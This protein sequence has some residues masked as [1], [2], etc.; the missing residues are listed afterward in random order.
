MTEPQQA[1]CQVC[2]QVVAV[3][4]RGCV[5]CAEASDRHREQIRRTRSYLSEKG[6]R[7]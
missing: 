4:E 1:Y 3:D 2:D 7:R 5:P 6:S